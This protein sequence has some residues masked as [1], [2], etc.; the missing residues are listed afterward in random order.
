MKH[1]IDTEIW[2]YDHNFNTEPSQEGD[3]PGIDYP[4]TVLRDPLASRFVRGVAFHGYAGTPVGMS[5][6]HKEF[7]DMPIYF[8]EGST[9]G[10]KGAEEIIALFENWASSYNAWVTC[11]DENR[12]PN[13]GPFEATWTMITLDSKTNEIAYRFDYFM[14][15]Q[16]MN[17]IHRGAVRVGTE[18]THEQSNHTAWKNPD[19]SMVLVVTNSQTAPTP[20]WVVAGETHFHTIRPPESVTTFVWRPPDR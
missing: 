4:L 8:T 3:D 18:S 15:G 17:F 6:L 1:G 16:F 12:G 13:R 20:L 5:L 9:F 10:V 11:I 7:P 14:Y 19:G 2:T